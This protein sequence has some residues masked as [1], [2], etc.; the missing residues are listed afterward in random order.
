M[1]SKS[2]KENIQTVIIESIE[3]K[4]KNYSPESNHMP[5]HYRL[6]G[7]DRMAL[8]SFIHS[9]N[10]TF[11]ISIF[12]PVAAALAKNNF[13]KVETQK[14][15]GNKVYVKC[16]QKAHEIIDTLTIDPH[17]N[18]NKE[19][20]I[21]R[22]NLNGEI[23]SVK[24]AKVDLFLETLSG[25]QFLFDLKT[26]KPNKGDFQKYKQTLLEW[27]AVILTENKNADVHTLISIPYNPYYPKSY[28]RWTMAGMLDIEKEL[29]VAEQF[30]DFLGG[31]GAYI[32]L[33][34]CFEKAG[35]ALS[36]KI[37]EYFAKVK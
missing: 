35:L 30:W 37:D 9:L 6:L 32:D 17:P 5:F 11:G 14:S 26:V 1:L 3:K 10:T 2:V 23:K 18:K 31:K 27:A 25:A 33:L 24:P 20:E 29:M 34:E 4:L 13:A 7:K 8:F 21:L 22:Q 12:E 15:V 19:L 28:E 16:Q 36:P